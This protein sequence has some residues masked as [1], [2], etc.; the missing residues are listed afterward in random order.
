MKAI[1]ILFSIILLLLIVLAFIAAGLMLF[2]NPNK[3]KPIFAAEVAKRTGYQ[4]VID[5]DLSW[6]FYPQFG[7]KINRMT[8]AKPNQTTPFAE[9]DDVRMASE[10]S[11]IIRGTEKLKGDIYIAKV[12]LMNLNA[13]DAKVSVNW[14]GS[15]LTLAPINAVFYNGTL[16]G[17]VQG[18]QFAT[19]PAWNWDIQLNNIQLKPL[20]IDLNG[21]DSKLQVD[22][23]GQVKLIAQTSGTTQEQ[24][25][26]NLQG[27]GDFSLTKGSVEGINLN[28][29]I[30]L[31][32]AL[33]NKQAAPSADNL[34]RTDF[35]SFT[36][37]MT[38]KS[39]LLET[40]KLN[41]TSATFNTTGTGSINLINENINYRLQVLPLIIKTKW[42]IPLLIDGKLSDPSVR[43]DMLT[44]QG[45]ITK[46]KLEQ[47]G[48]KV[49]DEIKKLP[50]QANDFLKRILGN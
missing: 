22:G 30:Q 32:D 48:Q 8:L 45:M 2:I 18:K 3:L 38:I 35:N 47:L 44:L 6:S 20:L 25:L 11:Q 36:G 26:E 43:L 49:E 42:S 12:K 46:D 24:L 16:E 28:Y 13:Q 21:A 39:G 19:T 29:Y 34:K 9:F 41:L 10:L 15:T 4:L 23:R 31:A 1:R 27:N 37:V 5:G 50:E 17:V 7:I 14:Q 33:I 40:K